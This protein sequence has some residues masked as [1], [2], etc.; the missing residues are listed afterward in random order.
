[1]NILQFAAHTLSNPEKYQLRTASGRVVEITNIVDSTKY[2]IQGIIK[3]TA[4]GLNSICEWDEN[5]YPHNLPYTH[6][7]NLLPYHAKTVY[8]RIPAS[9]FDSIDL[10]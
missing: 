8:E 9:Q 10:L 3:D 7:L 6:G 4:P 1:M 5:G 2:P